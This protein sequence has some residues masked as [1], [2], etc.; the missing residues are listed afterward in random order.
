MRGKRISE[1]QRKQILHLRHILHYSE[2]TIV[3]KLGIA[4]STVHDVIVDSRAQ[5]V[6]HPVQPNV[7]VSYDQQEEKAK[8]WSPAKIEIGRPR[9]PSQPEFYLGEGE[10]DATFR[11]EGERADE[12]GSFYFSLIRPRLVE[13]KTRPRQSFRE[14]LEQ[15]VCRMLAKYG[16]PEKR[17]RSTYDLLRMDRTIILVDEA[18][19]PFLG[20]AFREAPGAQ[21]AYEEI[22]A[23]R[24]KLLH[25]YM[26]A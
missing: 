6:Q 16:L 18:L 3:K 22:R 9:P 13:P 10:V 20:L 2:R 19:E 11:T 23:I 24:Q 15:E 7:Q 5:P 4:K 25:T 17:V 1:E 14:H 21:A 8:V 26:Q 12:F